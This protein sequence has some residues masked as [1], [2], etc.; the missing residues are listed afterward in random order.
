MRSK[1]A[2]SKVIAVVLFI[3]VVIVL[4]MLLWLFIKS[5][6][7]KQA[8]IS[9][10][11]TE[12]FELKVDITNAEVTQNTLNLVISRGSGKLVVKNITRIQKKAD[13]V[14]VIDS[15]GS[16][17]QEIND[18]K[19]IATDFADELGSSDIDYRIGLVEFRDYPV[20]DP[21][22]GDCGSL[23]QGDFPDK[24]YSFSGSPFT[25]DISAYESELALINAYGGGDPAE[26]HLTALN[27][28]ANLQFR[29]D[30]LKFFIVLTDAYPHAKDC[31]FGAGTTTYYG[32]GTGKLCY[33][34]PDYVQNVSDLLVS[35][36]IKLYYI[37]QESG[38]CGNKIVEEKMVPA[39]G[40][41]FFNYTESGGVQEIFM[42]L[43]TEINVEYEKERYDHLKVMLYNETSS[44]ELR[45]PYPPDNLPPPLPLETKTYHIPLNNCISNPTRVDVY[46]VVFASTGEPVIGQRLDSMN[47]R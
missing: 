5:L 3:I 38:M 42:Q 10:I 15:T 46:P 21:Y 19:A 24:V 18:V 9:Q 36:G 14:L 31:I 47:L 43:A 37:N 44:C 41:K 40:G 4:I 39:T 30:A 45:I 33:F 22:R 2:L 17:Q 20:G 32:A 6:L 8:E 25:S 13:I 23:S 29:T 1:K 35:K 7:T 11:K 26:A 16:M 28:S 27:D 12:L 34:G